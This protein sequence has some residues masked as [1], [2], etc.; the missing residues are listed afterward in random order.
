MTNRDHKKYITFRSIFEALHLFHFCH[1]YSY[2]HNQTNHRSTKKMFRMITK[3]L[4][5][6]LPLLFDLRVS[7]LP[8][9]NW[10]RKDMSNFMH[11]PVVQKSYIPVD[12]MAT[13]FG[14]IIRREFNFW[15]DFGI[16]R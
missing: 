14:K 7:A 12:N 2:S 3:L 13:A 1:F 15:R 16:G 6:L 4:L 10:I 11:R 9:N 8:Q 5:F